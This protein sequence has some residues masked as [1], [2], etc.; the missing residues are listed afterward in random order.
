MGVPIF[1]VEQLVKKYGIEV[2]SCNFTLIA[3][4]SL[5]VKSILRRFFDKVEDYSIDE[6]F[7]EVDLPLDQVHEM[8][9]EVRRIIGKG[10]GL[11]ISIGVS[12]TKTLA[13]VATRFAKKY[14]GY[15]GVCMIYT[16]TQR[17]KALSLT[18]IGDIWGIGRQHCKRLNK[19]GIVTALDWLNNMHPA[20]VRSFMRGVVAERTFRELQGISCLELEMVAP[21]KKNI[22]VSRGFG[23]N[24]N[25]PDLV[26]EA[27]SSYVVMAAAKLRK[28]HSKAKEIYVFLET[29]YHREDLQQAFDEIAIKLPVATSS[30]IE[31]AEYARIAL[32]ALFREGY[33]YKKTGIMVMDICDENAVQAHLF[34]H[35]DRAKEDRLMKAKD[36]INNRFGANTVKLASMGCGKRPWHIRQEKL[37]PFWSTRL[38]DI[39][40][41]KDLPKEMLAEESV[42]YIK[43]KPME[44]ISPTVLHP[45]P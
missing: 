6:M 16:D 15:E 13:K 9:C 35:R 8:C 26:A 23:N 10:L 17:E 12:T 14:P 43:M 42:P 2:F 40:V 22:M 34:N 11:P 29:N 24:I 5:R 18:H 7:C 19:I 31:I 45:S 44:G 39:P 41:T 32:K 33:T 38:S 36:H 30:D 27:L 37:P 21:P 25:D 20:S 4:I 28:Q 3:D 1:E